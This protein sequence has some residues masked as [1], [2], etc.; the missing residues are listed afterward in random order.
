MCYE[1][2]H[3]Y[4]FLSDQLKNTVRR[5]KHANVVHWESYVGSVYITG[6]FHF[7]KI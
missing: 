1:K 4:S 3:E 5:M 7:T 2:I 6:L